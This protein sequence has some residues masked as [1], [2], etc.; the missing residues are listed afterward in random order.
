MLGREPAGHVA[1]HEIYA[2]C[3]LKWDGSIGLA[4]RQ[5]MVEGASRQNSDKLAPSN[6]TLCPL[7]LKMPVAVPFIMSRIVAL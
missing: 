6:P 5:S 3:S 7:C 1:G 2:R 4:R